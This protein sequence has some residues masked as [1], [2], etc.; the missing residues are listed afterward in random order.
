MPN[1]HLVLIAYYFP[2]YNIIAAQR[3][4]KLATN[5]ANKG[6]KVTVLTLDEQFVHPDKIDYEF[7]KEVYS[8]PEIEIQKI[9][10]YGIG[11]ENSE[12]AGI[13]S[14][15]I[16]GFLSRLLCSNGIFWYPLLRKKIKALLKENPVDK[17]IAT[18]SPYLPF[19]LLYQLKRSSGL[20]YILDY[21][22][23]WTGNPRAQYFGWARKLVGATLE[24]QS[25]KYAHGVMT[26]S[27]GC[28]EALNDSMG[29]SA[30]KAMVVRNLPDETYKEF[31][32]RS[33]ADTS[34]AQNKIL[35]VLSGTV[36]KSCTFSSIL[37]ALPAVDQKLLEKLEFHYCGTSADLVQQEF[38]AAG[39]S[40][41][42]VNHGYVKKVEAFELLKKAS[43]LISLI[44]DGKLTY[45]A[46]VAGLMTTKIFDYFLTGKP[47]L[48]IGPAGCN[49]EAFA[50]EIAYPEFYSFEG[51][52]KEGITKFI[53]KMLN[54]DTHQVSYQ[55]VSLP[56]FDADF[57]HAMT[58]FES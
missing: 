17:I 11:Y 57:Q 54:K 52:D 29:M 31:F 13:I 23:L 9:P 47:I 2:P 46:S 21:R 41:L 7:C 42:L 50:K 8:R 15:L 49:T 12:K 4:A 26:V 34:H 36:Y 25:L 18:G 40:H 3:A 35:F 10:L 58:L 27:D 22:D 39:F 38:D 20:S 14:R 6:F 5:L 24:K 51:K 48:N 32:Y 37:K 53:E 1:K 43:V 55:R 33:Y 28:A 30:K 19:Y 44:D 45:D 56:D 16:S